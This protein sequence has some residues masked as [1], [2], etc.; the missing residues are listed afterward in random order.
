V[1]AS[2]G[3]VSASW[4][5]IDNDGR[6]DLF[7]SRQ[8]GQGLLF[9]QQSDGSFSQSSLPSG[10]FSW[11]AA[12]ADYD[13]DGFVDLLVADT[14]LNVLWHNN[15]QG[16]FIALTNTPIV[17]VPNAFRI[18]W[19]DYD[20]DGDL[21]LFIANRNA[22]S[23]FYR[24]DGNGVFTRL[25]NQTI[26]AEGANALTAAWGDYDNDGFFDV[27]IGFGSPG[28]NQPQRLYH[29]NGDGTFTRMTRAAVGSIADDAG[30]TVG[31]SWGDYDNDGW[32][33]LC[34]TDFL[35]QQNRLYHNNGDGT[36]TRI[37]AGA[38]V[39]D[40]GSSTEPI[41]GDYDRD[42]Y[43][44]LFIPNGTNGGGESNDYLYHNNGNSNAWIAVKCIGTRSNRSAIG[45]KVRAKATINGRN[46]WQLRAIGDAGA[47]NALEAHFGLGNATNVET[48]RIEWP[49]GTMQEF[50][51]VPSSQFLTIREPSRF[52]F[53]ATNG[54]AQL[55]LHGGR[56][57]QYD[58]Q[59]SSDLTAWSLLGTHTITNLNGTALIPDMNQP[60]S[61]RRFYRALL[62]P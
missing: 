30:I 44:D 52:I 6:I 38:V 39:T 61:G 9:R 46:F 50:H 53:G 14:T 28:G 7:V 4:A 43:L 37:L 47:G 36:F 29:N 60:A 58:I 22:D 41:W 49:S 56:N 59:T 11:G 15:G 17:T 42:G 19:T 20:N 55:S 26:P 10:G 57:L 54:V 8:S 25:T 45:A 40:R 3:S 24:N 16:A 32:L 23:Y 48:L 2:T 21:D 12:W 33:D 1:N 34:V 35:G 27:A 13:N 5:D 31:A 51:D 62:R 18:T